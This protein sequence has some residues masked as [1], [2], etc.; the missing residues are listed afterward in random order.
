MIELFD[1]TLR[2]GTQREGMALSVDDKLRITTKL[3]QLGIHFIEGGYAGANPKDDE[4]FR[5][6]KDLGL[7]QAK[8]VAFA[9]TRRKG[10]RAATD[11]TIKPLVDASTDVVCVF[12][13][14]WD[15]HVTET[16]GATLDEGVE[17]IKDTVGYLVEQGRTVIFDAEHFFD[18]FAA[19]PEYAVS[20]LAAARDAGATMLVL[21]DTNGGRLP[22][23]VGHTIQAV[24][25]ELKTPLGI[26]AHND[27]GCGV[28]NSLVAVK[29]GAVHVQGTMNG[30]GERAGNADL[31]AIIP[32]LKLKMG[33]DCVTDEQLSRLTET[34]HFVAEV[35]NMAP[36]A[37][38]PYVGHSAF[39]HKGGMHLA[40]VKKK[41]DAY[42]HI[43]PELVG[44]LAHV[45]V[46]ELAGRSTIVLKAKEFGIDLAEE[47]AKVDEVLKD[48][49]ELEQVGYHF[50]AA[51]GSFEMLLRTA[52]GVRK[53]FYKLE[54]FRVIMEK[55]EDDK[56]V[57]EATIKIWVGDE[58]F[59]ATAEGNGPVNALD[60]ALRL[61]VGRFYPE[62]DD[63]ELIDFK[64]RVLE[65]SK[66]T[67]AVTRVL[68][69][70]TDGVESWGTIGV[71]EN[72]IEAS[73]EALAD[74]VDYGLTHSRPGSEG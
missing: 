8:V 39:A 59:V 24:A 61:A 37:H 74:S 2:D 53:D 10:Q 16:L 14:T 55:R 63:I 5:R 9:A 18:G 4:F 34:A 58:R 70:T 62:L 31:V 50:E 15:V 13:K 73:W 60:G 22:F 48:I 46:S 57:T 52:M 1:T 72:I 32:A 51:D 20:C 11:V 12:G 23:E 64:V 6:A 67:G 38:Q 21:C 56:L 43:D 45:V 3:D 71:S 19:N 26:H 42:E 17:M 35:A 54:S 41:R 65:E 25:K 47:P 7:A 40:A 36:D 29:H 49:K 27:A 30:Y 66:G 33:L 69:E 44:N 28:A 68:I